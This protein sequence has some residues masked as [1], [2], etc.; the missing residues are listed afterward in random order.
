MKDT[1][2]MDEFLKLNNPILLFIEQIKNL[3]NTNQYKVKKTFISTSPR[4][5]EKPLTL[6]RKRFSPYGAW[7][8]A[9]LS[10]S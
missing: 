7:N 2:C 1:E 9:S 3:Q 4:N 8:S 5:H 10:S 6:S